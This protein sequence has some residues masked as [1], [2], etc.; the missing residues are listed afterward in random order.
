MHDKY[1]GQMGMWALCV[2]PTRWSQLVDP[3]LQ[4]LLLFDH[5]TDCPA[6]HMAHEILTLPV[7][8]A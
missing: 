4:P 7:M 6:V 5:G 3:V 8:H 1:S 2:L